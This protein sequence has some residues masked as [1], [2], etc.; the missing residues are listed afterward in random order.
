[1]TVPNV[2][3]EGANTKRVRRHRRATS[4]SL[5][6]FATQMPCGITTSR[7]LALTVQRPNMA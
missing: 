6:G 7:A 5:Q 3:V 4:L 2:G 1:M